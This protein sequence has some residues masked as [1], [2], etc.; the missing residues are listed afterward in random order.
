MFQN[1]GQLV[2]S[3]PELVTLSCHTLMYGCLTARGMAA[4]KRVWTGLCAETRDKKRGINKEGHNL[5]GNMAGKDEH[6]QESE[7]MASTQDR[8]RPEINQEERGT[9]LAGRLEG[10]KVDRWLYSL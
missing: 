4:G 10:R 7:A 8:V 5:E 2:D 6:A 3:A 9:A 1:R